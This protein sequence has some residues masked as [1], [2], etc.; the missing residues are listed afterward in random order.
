MWTEFTVFSDFDF[1]PEL[2]YATDIDVIKVASIEFYAPNITP[3][4]T[5]LEFSW[6]SNRMNGNN[7]NETILPVTLDNANFHVF[8]DYN[9]PVTVFKRKTKRNNFGKYPLKFD[10]TD[11]VSG[12]KISEIGTNICIRFL[13][14]YKKTQAYDPSDTIGY[15]GKII[16]NV[17]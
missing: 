12:K 14:K 16:S 4:T 8:R 3:N 1:A 13:I 2:N 17:A 5:F 9:V 15:R 7:N 10:I 6:T 11:L